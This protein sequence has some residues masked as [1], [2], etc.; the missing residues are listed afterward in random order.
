M[1]AILAVW[2]VLGPLSPDDS[3][4][5]G[6]VRNA[7]STG[8]FTNYYRWENSSEAPFTLVLHLLQPLVAL[9]SSPLVLRL[10]STVAGLLTWLLLSRGVLPL[11][12]P[13]RARSW[14]VRALLA[15]ALLVWWLPFNLGVRP[16]P[17]IALGTT[18]L[19]YTSP[20]P[21]DRG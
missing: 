6:I 12:L 3:F 13:E 15:A 7:L 16:E 19:L 9:H 2:A 4:T 17:F 21:R 5:E 1:L 11:V 14:R 10:P 8:D 20:S 18:C